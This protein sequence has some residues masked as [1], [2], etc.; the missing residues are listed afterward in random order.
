ML[1]EN[2]WEFQGGG[3]PAADSQKLVPRKTGLIAKSL[4]GEPVSLL[5]FSTI[6]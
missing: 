1:H 3:L 4:E 2:S 5:F 6:R